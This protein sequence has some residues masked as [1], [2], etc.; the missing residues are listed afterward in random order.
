MEKAQRSTSASTFQPDKDAKKIRL[1]EDHPDRVVA[2]GAG[3]DSK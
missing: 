1:D 3:L 2:I